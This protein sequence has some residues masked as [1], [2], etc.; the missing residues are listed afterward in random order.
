MTKLNLSKVLGLALG[1]AALVLGTI[2]VSANPKPRESKPFHA[3]AGTTFV[4]LPAS[5]PGGPQSHNIDGVVRV[6]V[7]GDCS[8]HATANLVA[9]TT[10]G[11]YLITDGI[12][13]FTSADGKSTLTASASFKG[14]S[15]SRP[16]ILSSL[17]TPLC[18]LNL[19][20]LQQ[21]P[22]PAKHVGYWMV[23]WIIDTR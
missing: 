18:R 3:N 23:I 22:A 6:S 9:T 13:L 21:G 2:Y 15:C 1:C 10:P 5:T 14:W 8:F 7:L 11:S 16:L 19:L 4:L 17:T 20:H 12:F